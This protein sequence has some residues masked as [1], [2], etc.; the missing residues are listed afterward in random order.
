MV[1][2]LWWLLGKLYIWCYLP[3]DTRNIIT[4]IQ[5]WYKIKSS[6]LELISIYYLSLAPIL[7]S[8]S[9]R[10]LCD[11]V[12]RLFIFQPTSLPK[13]PNHIGFTRMKTESQR[14]SLE[15]V[16]AK[17][18]NFSCRKILV[19]NCYKIISQY[20]KF[21]RTSKWWI[22][23]LQVTQKVLLRILGDS[24]A[25]SM[26]EVETPLNHALKRGVVIV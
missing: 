11:S 5:T 20:Y 15:R 12:L 9:V 10:R 24:H 19:Y 7:S 23:K 2:D 25:F 22:R 16:G 4:L 18:I 21:Q 14:K 3:T 13:G 26:F 17:G 1:L 8:L 6:S